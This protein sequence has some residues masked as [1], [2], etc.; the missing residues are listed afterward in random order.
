MATSGDT[1]LESGRS[2]ARPATSAALRITL[3]SA[4]RSDIRVTL[5]T[6]LMAALSRTFSS[7]MSRSVAA[8][9]LRNARWD[10]F[11]RSLRRYPHSSARV[12]ALKQ[13]YEHVIL[14]P[15]Y[16]SVPAAD[17]LMG[18]SLRQALCKV[19]Y[20]SVYLLCGHQG[21]V[22]SGISVKRKR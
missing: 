18:R 11:A 7:R 21:W 15:D 1:T 8:C 22:G 17:C 2:D 14:R 12:L 5:T 9:R 16:P 20:Y 19:I 6:S 13:G 3:R 4:D 10:S